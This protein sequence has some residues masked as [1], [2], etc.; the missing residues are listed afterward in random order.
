MKII[1]SNTHPAGE[2]IGFFM[3]REG[4]KTRQASF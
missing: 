2:S 4:K 3:V 1:N